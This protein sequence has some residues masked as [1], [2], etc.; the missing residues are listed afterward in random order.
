MGFPIVERFVFGM[1]R[2]GWMLSG[3]A[4]TRRRAAEL[5]I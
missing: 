5:E 4:A 3:T 1:E 2:R